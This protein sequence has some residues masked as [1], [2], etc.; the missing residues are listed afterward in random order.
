MCLHGCGAGGP[1][2]AS[3]PALIADAPRNEMAT[4]RAPESVEQHLISMEN[5]KMA[6]DVTVRRASQIFRS[7]PMDITK[8][9]ASASSYMSLE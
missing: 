8:V 9:H 4:A 2:A 3:Q 7:C 6:R 1:A 5:V